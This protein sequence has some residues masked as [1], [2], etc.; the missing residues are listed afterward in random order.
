MARIVAELS[1]CSYRICR[2]GVGAGEGGCRVFRD[3]AMSIE[4]ERALI[5]SVCRE[6][7]RR[8]TSTS[9]QWLVDSDY[10]F[11]CYY[12][13]SGTWAFREPIDGTHLGGGK[14]CEWPLIW[15]KLSDPAFRK[16]YGL[17][18]TDATAHEGSESQ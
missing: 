15:A 2:S 17:E 13:L 10:V 16:R 12:K 6:P 5:A 18:R 14:N 3:I 8:P 4:I 11:V 7:D 9:W 1:A